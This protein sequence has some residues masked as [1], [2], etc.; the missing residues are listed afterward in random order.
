MY[1]EFLTVDLDHEILHYRYTRYVNYNPQLV[2][3]DNLLNNSKTIEDIN[4]KN[5]W[6]VQNIKNEFY[7]I[8]KQYK[9]I[10]SFVKR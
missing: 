3:I 5:L 9:S 1:N 4:L 6:R 7:F 2:T 8:N 10:G